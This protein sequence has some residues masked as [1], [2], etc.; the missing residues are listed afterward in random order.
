MG[1][2]VAR[3]RGTT[4]RPRGTLAPTSGGAGRH[5]TQPTCPDASLFLSLIQNVQ[6]QLQAAGLRSLLF[7]IRSIQAP[8]ISISSINF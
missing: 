5:P 7:S 4:E 6:G 1:E 8:I 2:Q 3:D